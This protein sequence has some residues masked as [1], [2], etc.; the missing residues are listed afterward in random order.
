[1]KLVFRRAVEQGRVLLRTESGGDSAV[2]HPKLAVFNTG[3]LTSAHKHI[4]LRLTPFSAI[5]A[6][7]RHAEPQRLGQH[8]A[9]SVSGERGIGRYNGIVASWS[10]DGY[11][12]IR[13]S[14]LCKPKKSA[15]PMP[16]DTPDDGSAPASRTPNSSRSGGGGLRFEESD[17]DSV[18]DTRDGAATPTG[19]VTSVVGDLDDEESG[20][21]VSFV[22]TPASASSWSAP[23]IL[24]DSPPRRTIPIVTTSVHS[25]TSHH[26]AGLGGRATGGSSGSSAGASDPSSLHAELFVHRSQVCVP[27]GVLPVLSKGMLVE[28]SVGLNPVSRGK[29]CCVRVTGPGGQALPGATDVRMCTTFAFFL[30]C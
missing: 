10:A 4:Y 20:P 28:F 13:V 24:S 25:R 7:P 2:Q 21:P 14:G 15:A 16:D 8:G 30:S 17:N 9:S 18:D 27:D 6:E 23:D 12:R 29:M 22:Q 1:M 5:S 3:L 26:A 19:S 11:G